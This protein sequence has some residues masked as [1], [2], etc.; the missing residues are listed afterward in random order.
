MV[1]WAG[2]MGD[3]LKDTEAVLLPKLPRV[4]VRVAVE[5]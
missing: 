1:L 3:P 2:V 5:G 4:R